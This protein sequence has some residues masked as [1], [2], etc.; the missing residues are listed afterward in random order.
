[1]LTGRHSTHQSRGDRRLNP[2]TTQFLNPTRCTRVGS[3]SV[4]RPDAEN[5]PALAVDDPYIPGAG[6]HSDAVGQ[7]QP[8]A[9][10]IRRRIDPLDQ[11]AEGGRPDGAEARRDAEGG[12]W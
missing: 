2:E 4:R 8:A 7:L 6:R 3:A 12:A 5:A 10:L 11:C 1:M 9:D